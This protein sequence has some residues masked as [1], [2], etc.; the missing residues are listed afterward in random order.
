MKEKKM[1]DFADKEDLRHAWTSSNQIT[2]EANI[3]D[4][5][6]EDC[7]YTSDRHSLDFSIIRLKPLSKNNIIASLQPAKVFLPFP[8]CLIF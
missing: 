6:P 3:D 1:L 5:H 7:F 8:M 4:N 2:E